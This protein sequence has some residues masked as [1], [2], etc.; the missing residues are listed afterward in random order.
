MRQGLAP[1]SR[2]WRPSIQPDSEG[3]SNGKMLLLGQG[4]HEQERGDKVLLLGQG[5]REQKQG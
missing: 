3:G 1:S 5:Q 2:R 4:Q